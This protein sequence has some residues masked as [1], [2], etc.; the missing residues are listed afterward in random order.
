M[1]MYTGWRNVVAEFVA[2]R[3][4]TGPADHLPQTV[5]W[6]LLAVALSAYQQWLDDPDADLADLLAR[7]SH[8][9]SVGLT[10]ELGPMGRTA[11]LN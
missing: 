7:G 8:I 10:T 3:T 6:T 5:A 1:L 11:N 2:M 4:G 9:L